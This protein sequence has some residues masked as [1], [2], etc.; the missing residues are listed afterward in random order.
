MNAESSKNKTFLFLNSQGVSRILKNFRINQVIWQ[1]HK[2]VEGLIDDIYGQQYHLCSFKKKIKKEIFKGV[3][4][5]II[6]TINKIKKTQNNWSFR[7]ENSVR[8]F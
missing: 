4:Q 3:N 1:W 8:R 6:I 5:F 7:N 2:F